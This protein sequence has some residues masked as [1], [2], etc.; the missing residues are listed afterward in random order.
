MVSACGDDD[1]NGTTAAG[2]ERLDVVANFYPLAEA[3]TRVGGERVR[4]NNLTPAGV[5]PHDIELTSR[6]VDQVQDADVV[7]YLGG[8]FQLAVE[9]VAEGRD[10]GAVDVL[11]LI[12]LD[13]G[14]VG[15]LEEEE[16]HGAEEA[17][18][19]GEEEHKESGLDPH[20]WLDPQLLAGAVD[21]VADTL[22]EAS[23]DGAEEFKANAERYKEELG[24]LDTELQ[25]GLATCERREM[26]TSHAAF[27]YLARRYGLTQS[28]I[29]GLSPEAEP[30]AA[31]LGDLTD[32]IKAKGITTVFYEEL[33]SP[34]VAETLAREAGV[35]TA[36]LSPIEGLSKDQVEAGKDYAGVMR[37]N[38]AALRNALGC[39]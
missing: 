26:V 21:T 13:E 5:E 6:Q 37:D 38:L 3:A 22:A 19:A 35:K 25:R 17:A 10:T 12:D 30:D 8:G 11:A 24:A 34:R 18:A 27:F 32:D 33:V 36:V 15:A 1:G 2:D 7:F 20:F 16:E 28:P 39:T 4:V 23:P 31:R 29:A 9:R 14:A